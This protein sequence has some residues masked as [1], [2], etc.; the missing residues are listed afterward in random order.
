MKKLLAAGAAVA[1][2]GLPTLAQAQFLDFSFGGFG[3]GVS[4]GFGAPYY[5]GYYGDYYGGGFGGFGYPDYGYGGFGYPYGGGYYG[6]GFGGGFGDFGFG[7]GGPFLKVP[8]SRAGIR[9]IRTQGAATLGPRR[10]S[11][12]MANGARSRSLRHR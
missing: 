12:R 5:G 3:P 10:V 8:G 2:L 9:A 1:F 6:T 4:V 7:F 11:A